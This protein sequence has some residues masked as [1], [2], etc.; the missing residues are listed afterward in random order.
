MASPAGWRARGRW[1]CWSNTL[2]LSSV[3]RRVGF[4]ARKG[5]LIAR[6]DRCASLNDPSRSIDYNCGL[7]QQIVQKVV[8]AAVGWK[9]KKIKPVRRVINHWAEVP[10]GRCPARK[11]YR[12]GGAGWYCRSLARGTNPLEI[13]TGPEA[14]ILPFAEMATAISILKVIMSRLAG[15]SSPLISEQLLVP[16]QE[17]DLQSLE[18]LS[19]QGTERDVAVAPASLPRRCGGR[20]DAS[21]C[22]RNR[23]NATGGRSVN[24][25]AV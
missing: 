15:W 12:V 7:V 1:P 23:D 14:K 21:P 11:K 6:N 18:D 2:W 9:R 24:G 16:G 22:M 20:D 25:R 10:K 19:R 8:T 13:G 4:Y 5:V 17:N 3:V